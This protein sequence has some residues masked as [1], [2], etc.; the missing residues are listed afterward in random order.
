MTAEWVEWT[1][2]EASATWDTRLA[3]FSD[4]NAYQ[5]YRWGEFKRRRWLVRRGSVLINGAPVAMAQCLVREFGAPKVALVWVPGG[6]VGASEGRRLLP[7]LLRQRYRG[8]RLCVRMNALA[9]PCAEELAALTAEGWVRPR[10]R[11]APSHTIH[12][13]LAPEEPARRSALTA[14]WRHNLTRGER[15]TPTIRAWG[16]DEPLEPVYAVYQDMLRYKGLR[17]SMSCKDLQAI[18]SLW[19]PDFTL[20]VALTEQ[21]R[22]CAVRA[23]IRTHDRAQ[24]FLAAVS[25]AGRERYAAYPVL[26]RLLEL[27]RSG[28]VRL[29]DLNGVDPEGA[30]GVF[31][32]KRGLGGRLVPLVGE[33]EWATAAWLRLGVNLAVRWR[34]AL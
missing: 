28:G 5:A 15:R 32:F 10:A 34:G 24:D 13:D 27:A 9:E 20:V 16:A 33:W 8:W 19:G 7:Q 29:Y 6:P 4:C 18:R 22:P 31:N 30:P 17:P 2:A 3:A 1:A 25:A 12:L 23:F 21:G 14:N 11:L 26:W